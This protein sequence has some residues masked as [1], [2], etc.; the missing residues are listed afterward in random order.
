ARKAKSTSATATAVWSGQ[1]VPGSN[2]LV[3]YTY[4]GDANLDGKINVDDYGR[5]DLN[6]PLGTSGW[7]NGDFNYDD[8]VNVDDYATIAFNI[9]IQGPPFPS[10][11]VPASAE[12]GQPV[13]DKDQ[14]SE[15]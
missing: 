14:L 10:A 1:T 8:K 11:S 5:I 6:V 4:A 13:R 9:A 7:F 3:M 12:F 15:P 2:T